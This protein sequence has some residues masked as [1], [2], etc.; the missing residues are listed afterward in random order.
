MVTPLFVYIIIGIIILLVLIC[1]FIIRYENTHF[2][3]TS[4]ELKCP[5]LKKKVTMAVLADLHDYRYGPDN[6]QLMQAIDE[7]KPDMVVS[8]G[9]MITDSCS[10]GSDAGTF[11]FLQSVSEKYTFVYGCGNHEDK[12]L[13]R[14]KKERN[15]PIKRLG[16]LD[17]E[18]RDFDEYGI[19]F[20]GLNLEYTYF[21]KV[22]LRKTDAEHIKALVGE[23]SEDHLNILMGHNPDQFD[24]YVDWGADLVLAG[25]IHGG[26]V[27]TPWHRGLVSP[28]FKLFPSY[29]R[30]IFKRGNTTMVLSA[31]LGNHTIHVRM[32]NPAELIKLELV[33]EN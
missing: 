17:N 2:K 19:R 25:H 9:D 8:A 15:E 5:K 6:E 4:Y 12:R 33:P 24:A 28:M 1:F 20:Y 18:C 23:P 31:G 13:R 3:V 14:D 10:D 7:I 16:I 32:F 27:A 29:D 21:R 30:G 26:M 11:D 22:I